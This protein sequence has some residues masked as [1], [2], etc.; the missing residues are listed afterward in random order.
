M[1]AE[2]LAAAHRLLVEAVEELRAAAGPS[3]E[4]D[5][6]LSVLTMCEGATRRLDRLA[7]DAVAA[8]QRRGVFAERGYRNPA[9]ALADLLGWERFEARRRVVAA[10]QVCAR[11]GLDGTPSPPRLPATAAAFDAGAAGLR[12]VE[13]IARVL[14]SAAAGRL[15]PPVWAGAEAQLAA[16]AAHYTP[17]ELAAWGAALVD[18][19]DADGPEPD[20]RA[21]ALVNELSLT[22]RGAGGGVLKGRFD[23]PALFDA[24]ATVIDT[25]A[26]PLT[27]DDDRTPVQRQAEALAEVCGYVLDHGDVPRR[28]G[29]RPHLTVLV[30]LEDLEDRARS[31][32]LDFG[33]TLPPASL[34]MLA[35][36]AAVV[37]VVMSGAGQPLDIGQATRTVPD[38]LRRAVAARDGG[39]AHP[40]CGRPPSWCEIH[41]VREWANGGATTLDN[42][43]MLCRIHHRLLHHSEWVVRIRDGIPEFIPPRWIDPLQAPRRRPPPHLAA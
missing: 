5:A 36:D 30:R 29:A 16:K 27:G 39:C 9:G 31:A 8:L 3:A 32:M 15:T 28:G 24:I 22:R 26:R 2:R 34:R 11:I 43:V 35:C 25:K 37:P 42:L 1:S 38:G 7:V 18:R 17:S 21:P 12:H 10:E 33:G 6:L 13:V 19:L 40:G 23:D 4:D 14:N 20:D 41:H